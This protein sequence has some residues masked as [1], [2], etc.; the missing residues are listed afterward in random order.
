MTAPLIPSRTRAVMRR[1]RARTL[2]DTCAVQVKVSVEIPG[3]TQEQW[4]TALTLPCRLEQPTTADNERFAAGQLTAKPDA[5]VAFA[6]ATTIAT[7]S[8]LVVTGVTETSAGN[9]AWSRT[10]EIVGDSGPSSVTVERRYPARD[11]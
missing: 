10:L 5:V 8:R 11:V 7:T 1:V 9:V 4:S 6:P 2:V 3:G